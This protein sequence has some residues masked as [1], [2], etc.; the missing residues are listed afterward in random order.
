MRVNEKGMA[1][2]LSIPCLEA[3]GYNIL[4]D[5]KKEWV[6]TT[7][8]GTRIK[9]KQD[10]GLYK[11]MPYIDM[12][13]FKEGAIMIE[14]VCKNFENFTKKEIEVAKLSRDIQSIIGHPPDK[15]FKQ[16]VSDGTLKNCLVVPNDVSNAAT[17]FGPNLPRMQGEYQEKSKYDK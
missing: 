6:V 15:V 14:T 3:D 13:Q 11:G 17:I 12:R 8:K 4:Y 7:P 5:T 2:L 16:I 1:N 10:T 9:F